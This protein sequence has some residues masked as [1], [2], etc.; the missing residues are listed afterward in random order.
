MSKLRGGDD[1]SRWSGEK[2]GS[3]REWSSLGWGTAILGTSKRYC[4]DAR[5]PRLATDGRGIPRVGGERR[6]GKPAAGSAWSTANRRW[7]GG[8]VQVQQ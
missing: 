3:G 1:P 2:S 5:K 8:W 7:R 6:G 4:A